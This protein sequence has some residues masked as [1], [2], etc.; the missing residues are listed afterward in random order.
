VSSFW[1]PLHNLPR[2][3]L[4]RELY[5]LAGVDLTQIDGVSVLTAQ[6]VLSEIGWDMS[7][8][9]T[10]KH[11]A[12]WLGL[13]PNN[14]ITGGKVKKRGRRKVHNRVAQALRVAARSLHSSQSALG[15]FYRRIKAKYGP[16]IANV[17]AAHKMA[18]IIYC[19]LK[20]KTEYR[21]IGPDEYDA[22]YRE[23]QFRNLERQ[24][25]RLGYRLQPGAA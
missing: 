2:F 10:E 11:F 23:R 1:G 15:N 9:R 13:C 25:A 12:S 24:A 8:W 3:D 19:M 6:V 21:D 5:R 16:A 7:K 22:R 18:R 4:R 20:N 14:K 17:A